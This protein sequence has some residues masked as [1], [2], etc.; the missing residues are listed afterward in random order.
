MHGIALRVATRKHPD[1]L[2][3]MLACGDGERIALQGIRVRMAWLW[4]QVSLRRVLS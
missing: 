4:N 3:S 2:L 1:F